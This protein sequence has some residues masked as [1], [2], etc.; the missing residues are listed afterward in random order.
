MKNTSE[1]VWDGD[2]AEQSEEEKRFLKALEENEKALWELL[3]EG[4]WDTLQKYEA[5][6]LEM[7]SL[8]AAE[9]FIKDVRFA[10]AHMPDAMDKKGNI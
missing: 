5:R 10:T 7:G 4:L 2:P 6:L 3:G 1:T 9:A 8:P